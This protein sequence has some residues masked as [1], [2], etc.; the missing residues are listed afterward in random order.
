MPSM[1]ESHIRDDVTVVTIPLGASITPEIDMGGKRLA[2]IAM[3]AAWTTA[4]LTF[5]VSPISGGSFT[6]LYD[7]TGTEYTV[8]ASTSRTIIIPFA[9]FIGLKFIKIRSGTTGTPVVQAADRIL[10]ISGAA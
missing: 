2:R 4:N 10:T 5:Q 7:S 8:T 1:I 3:P 9:D 6:D